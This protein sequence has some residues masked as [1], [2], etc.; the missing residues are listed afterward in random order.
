MFTSAAAGAQPPPRDVDLKAT[1]GTLLKA[2]YF[3]A[4]HPGPAV[5]L[6][7]MCVTTREAWAPVARGL[8]AAGINTLTI[9]NR[10]FGDSGGP[11]FDLDNPD[12][13]RELGQ[14][15]PGDFDAAFAW[16]TAQPGVDKT[17][18]GAGGASCGV[19][20]AVKLASRHHEIRALALLAGGTD[21]AGVTYLVENPS[22]PIFASAAADDEFDSHAPELMRW[23]AELT[24][25]T[26]NKFV[27]FADGRHGTEIFG[28]HPELPRQIVS[29]FTDV[30]ASP[31]DT[32]A[33]FTPKKTE[34]S[35]FWTVASR[36]GGAGD[37]VRMFRDA[38][39]RDPNAFLFPEFIL[40]QLAYSRLQAG[41]KDDAVTLFELNVEAFPGS[42]NAR[43]SL[44]DGYVARGQNDLA[45]ASAQKSLELLPGD[46]IP[47]RFK[48]AIRKSAEEKIAKLKR[49]G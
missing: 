28:P 20:N 10:G 25:N 18:L 13:Q 1:D 23:F 22:L 40:N 41:G 24:S 6:L 15:W 7:H 35:E 5:M 31:A 39:K 47:D 38:R 19:N 46:R 14:K 3:A 33:A 37:A 34:A 29:W 42:A 26:R 4:A 8:S 45:L 17:R 12:V 21:A 16:L 36:P 2:T 9:D 44:A 32:N 49:G 27:G 43:D 30:L 48:A 11:R